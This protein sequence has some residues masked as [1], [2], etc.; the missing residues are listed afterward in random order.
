MVGAGFLDA[1]IVKKA[2]SCE[3][4][5][6]GGRRSPWWAVVEDGRP[7]HF[8]VAQQRSIPRHVAAAARFSRGNGPLPLHRDGKPVPACP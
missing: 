4:C 2:S 8:C 1:P 6:G 7:R 3:L 5:E